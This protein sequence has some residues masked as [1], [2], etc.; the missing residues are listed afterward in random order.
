M[1]PGQLAG[2]LEPNNSDLRV[3]IASSF[4]E[5]HIKRHSKSR[6]KAPILWQLATP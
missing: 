2:L 1:G 3:W 4:F 5:H 6:R